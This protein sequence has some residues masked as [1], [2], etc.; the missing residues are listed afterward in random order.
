MDK[1]LG[2]LLAF[3]LALVASTAYAVARWR[4]SSG[5]SPDVA[6]STDASPPPPSAAS[7]AGDDE[8][9]RFWVD[10]VSAKAKESGK[11]E[12]PSPQEVAL[13]MHLSECN[14]AVPCGERVLNV[15]GRIAEGVVEK[16]EIK[17]V[18]D[19]IDYWSL[20]VATG[21]PVPTAEQILAKGVGSHPCLSQ[22]PPCASEM[23]GII[24]GLRVTQHMAKFEKVDAFNQHERELREQFVRDWKDGVAAKKVLEG[25]EAKT[26][27]YMT[28]CKQ[29]RLRGVNC[30][31]NYEA[32][33]NSIRKELGLPVV[34]IVPGT[35]KTAGVPDQG[36]DLNDPKLDEITFYPFDMSSAADGPMMDDADTA[37]LE[38]MMKDQGVGPD[39]SMAMGEFIRPALEAPASTERIL[40]LLAS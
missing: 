2:F 4:K 34:G 1:T 12:M 18:V 10:Q 13:R 26:S 25:E 40:S 5:G 39:Q 23:R 15:M 38:Q 22:T 29:K 6:G 36:T 28:L 19:A 21:Y 30:D 33:Q 11:L 32:L 14:D 24:N 27:A 16:K 37:S 35:T 20:R 3:V 7:P 17:N 8:Q 31:A 9:V